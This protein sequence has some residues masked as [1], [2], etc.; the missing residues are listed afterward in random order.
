MSIRQRARMDYTAATV[1][2]L[3]D[4]TLQVMLISAGVFGIVGGFVS[5]SDKQFVGRWKL[6]IALLLF[7]SSAVLGYLLHG[8][9]ISQ[10][11]VAKFDAFDGK[12]VILGLAQVLCFFLGGV[13]FTIFV[14]RNV[15]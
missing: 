14:M 13:F 15:K 3:R 12:L 7:A 11:S 10:L 1:E 4:L 2:T 8:V 5:S 9:L 6:G